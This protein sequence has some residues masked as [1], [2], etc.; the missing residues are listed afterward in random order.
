[1]TDQRDEKIEQLSCELRAATDRAVKSEASVRLLTS[2]VAR[3]TQACT[4]LQREM[5]EVTR[6]AVAEHDRQRE[7]IA[8]LQS[9]LEYAMRPP[10][11]AAK[12]KRRG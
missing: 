7:K 8:S 4:R 11:A 2:D 1:M 12:G 10:K 6:I 5:D 9:S 3:L